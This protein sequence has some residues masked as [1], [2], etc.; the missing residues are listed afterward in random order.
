MPSVPGVP[1]HREVTSPLATLLRFELGATAVRA[2]AVVAVLVALGAGVVA[3][4]S[5]PTVDPVAPPTAGA[6]SATPDV[7]VVAVMGRVQRPGLVEIPAGSRVADAIAA[8][9]GPLPETDLS[10]LNLARKLVDGEMITVGVPEPSSGAA[11]GGRVNLNT[12]T[13]AEL[14]ALPG[15]GPVLA[16]RII[17]Y[18][19]EHGGFRSVDEL[20]EVS[21]IGDATFA[22]LEPRV[23]V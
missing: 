19:E 14:E 6:V 2:L 7:I 15:V 4:R 3:W 1:N 12:A 17:A 18:R 20:R 9:G 11:A 13:A 23:T 5:R 22:E 21:G 10:T 16:Q 8:A